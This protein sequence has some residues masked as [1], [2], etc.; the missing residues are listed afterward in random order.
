MAPGGHVGQKDADLTVVDL[1]GRA[2]ILRLDTRRV[3]ATFGEAAFI[4]DEH[5]EEWC[6][7]RTRRRDRRRV[8]GLADQGA[9]DIAYAVFVPDGTREQAL[10]AIGTGL[11][12]L[13]SDLPTIFSGNVTEESL[14]VEQGVLADFGARKMG[15]QTLLHLAQAQRPGANRT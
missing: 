6:G 3:T 9:Q 2:A 15:S 11:F 12:G 14:Q 13:F 4:D 7:L 8:Q 10:H 5:W 1:S